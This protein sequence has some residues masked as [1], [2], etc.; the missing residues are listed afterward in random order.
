MCP[1][2][3][4]ES[5][6]TVNLGSYHRSV[7]PN[8][9][10]SIFCF[11]AFNLSTGQTLPVTSRGNVLSIRTDDVQFAP[12]GGE[13]ENKLVSELRNLLDDDTRAQGIESDRITT[14]EISQC[15]TRFRQ[16]LRSIL[17]L[18]SDCTNNVHDVA[19][20]EL[21][22]S[23]ED[24]PEFSNSFA[25]V[26]PVIC[27]NGV[28]STMLPFHGSLWEEPMSNQSNCFIQS[29]VIPDTVN[30]DTRVTQLRKVFRDRVIM[31]SGKLLLQPFT[32]IE[33]GRETRAKLKRA[34][35]MIL[36]QNTETYVSLLYGTLVSIGRSHELMTEHEMCMLI[37][38]NVILTAV[39]IFGHDSRVSSQELIN[40]FFSIL[41]YS[42]HLGQLGNRSYRVDLIGEDIRKR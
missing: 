10:S 34:Q 6:A 15:A 18:Y 37:V 20:I 5:T 38:Q 11:Y 19:F 24:A 40:N 33:N 30:C 25:A 7:L 12:H 23:I 3:M 35:Y 42:M 2:V 41:C 36:R 4:T 31:M 9:K 39:I 16:C 22:F 26:V 8:N 21:T 27:K 28:V 14:P 1:V 32:N 29:S 13:I 17:S